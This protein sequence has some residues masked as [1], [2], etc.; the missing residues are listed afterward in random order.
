MSTTTIKSLILP[1]HSVLHALKHGEVVVV[2]PVKPQPKHGKPFQIEG[3]RSGKWHNANPL[4]PRHGPMFSY[5]WSC[6]FGEPGDRLRVLEDGWYDRDVLPQL[7]GLR[8]FFPDGKMRHESGVDAVVI[9]FD[10]DGWTE[11]LRV[12]MYKLNSSL[13]FIEASQMPIWASRL[14]LTLS[15]VRVC[16][17]QG[18]TEKEAITTGVLLHPLNGEA[19]CSGARFAFSRVWELQHPG[20]WDR[21][22]W[23]FICHLTGEGK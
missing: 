11:D 5:S 3:D 15:S 7:D 2:V 14:T 13:R 6:P 21:N 10:G 19:T 23:A 4:Y 18:V 12:Q 22:D 1:P 16:Q 20:A 17:V 8:V 9:P